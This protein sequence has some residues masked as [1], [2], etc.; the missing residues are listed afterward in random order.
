M[1]K[2][3]MNILLV[4]ATFIGCPLMLCACG[5]GDDGGGNAGGNTGGNG[6]GS[7]TTIPTYNKSRNL[8]FP[9]AEGSASTITGGAAGTNVYIVTN[10][11]DSGTGS[12]RDAV[13][14]SGRTI[15]FAVSG[16]INLDTNLEINANNLTIAGQT[17]PGDGICVAG[18]PVK[19]SG[20]TNVIIRYMRFRLGNQNIDKANFNADAGDALEVKDSKNV[21]IDHCSVSWSTDECFSTPRVTNFTM[22]YC[23]ISESLKLAGHSK[24]NHGYGGI[25]GGE[26]ATYH[27][28]LLADHD[29][30]NPRFGH[31]YTAKNSSGNFIMGTIDYVNNVV[32]N[33]GGNST[34]GGEGSSK[35][36]YVNMVNN[37]YK[38][39]PNTGAPN[40]LMQLTSHCTNCVA[41]TGH[42][43]PAKIFLQGNIVNGAA[44]DWN[45]IDMDG[46]KETRDKTALKNNAMLTARY[47]TGLT[48][49]IANPESATEAYEHVLT[50][51]GASLKRDAVDERIVIQVR[52][53]TGAIINKVEDTGSGYPTLNSTTAP[54]DLDKDGM[55]DAWEEA[56][57][58]TLGV[59]GKSYRDLTAHA[60]NLSAHYTNLEVYLNELVVNT[61][62]SG[63]N[64]SATR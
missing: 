51:A 48:P 39:G 45:N 2:K 62:P 33:W 14:M 13:S 34:Y 36:Y 30:R 3:L 17:A 32:Y 54:A 42:A 49:Y 58:A 8:A 19:I 29:S 1:K 12:F 11:N 5:G 9:G 22:Q 56:Q 53:N 57:L 23:I 18:Y 63:A 41:E 61:F 46:S 59:T 24:G 27:H 50:F 6:G 64:A 60:Y 15:V 26:N 52:N 25:W 7:T 31:Q 10:T 37:Y 44:A 20:A 43:Q 35:S 47:T 55:P 4:I 40:R 28:N 38:H 16:T 21:L